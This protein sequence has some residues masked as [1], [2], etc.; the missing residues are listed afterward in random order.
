MRPTVVFDLVGQLDG[1]GN[2]GLE[3]ASGPLHS[4]LLRTI[5]RAAS[6]C[7]IVSEPFSD[8]Y[9]LSIGEGLDN[10]FDPVER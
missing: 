7:D 8:R 10:G 4:P 6:F 2:G 1:R 5:R 3:G 9:R